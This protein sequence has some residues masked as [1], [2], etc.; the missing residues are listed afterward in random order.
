MFAII[1]KNGK[2]YRVS[3]GE[4]IKFDKINS[5]PGGVFETEEILAIS[6]KK[7]ELQLGSPII[8]GAKVV[9][10]ILSHGKDK[11]IIVFKRK[12]RKTYRRKY[13]HRQMHTL[14]K[15]ESIKNKTVSDKKP[16]S[17]KEDQKKDKAEK[18]SSKKVSP[19]EAASKKV[20]ATKKIS[21]KKINKT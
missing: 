5:E 7:G 8:D 12:R 16:K 17:E 18:T 3:K 9:G 14:V 2:Q 20:S 19:P 13:G 11:K 10:K 4:T 6:E 1:R 15:I 21:T